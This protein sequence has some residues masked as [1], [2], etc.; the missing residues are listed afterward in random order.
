MIGAR[1][2]AATKSP[3]RLSKGPRA[4]HRHLAH[5]VFKALPNILVNGD[6]YVC[7]EMELAAMFIG[8]CMP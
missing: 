5:C 2:L 8:V 3:A 4:K 7:I 6:L 1:P